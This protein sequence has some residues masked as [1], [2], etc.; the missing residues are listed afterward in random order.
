MRM[1]V[2][3]FSVFPKEIIT[4]RNECHIIQKQQYRYW[5]SKRKLNNKIA[6]CY[7][8]KSSKIEKEYQKPV[9]EHIVP[10]VMLRDIYSNIYCSKHHT[11]APCAFIVVLLLPHQRTHPGQAK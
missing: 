8:Q 1:R 5:L 9:N 4:I 6:E 10:P 11:N 2:I 7:H 3:L